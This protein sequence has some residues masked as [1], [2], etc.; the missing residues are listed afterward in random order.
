MLAN[1]CDPCPP[2]P[3]TGTWGDLTP[4]AASPAL[5]MLRVLDVRQPHEFH[6]D[7]GHVPGAELV[8]LDQLDAALPM[9]DAARPVLVVCRSGKRAAA[10]CERLVANGFFAVYNLTGGMLAWNADGRSACAHRHGASHEC[11]RAASRRSA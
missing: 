5:G 6:G 11:R 1:Q 3:D 9:L 4:R 7:L 8:P 10:A 2:I